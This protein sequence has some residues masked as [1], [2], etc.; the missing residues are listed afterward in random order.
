MEL[1]GVI[2]FLPTHDLTATHHFYADLLHLPLVRDQGDCRIYRVTATAY[3]GFCLRASR[4]VPP[5][6]II[7]TLLVE[8]VEA[9]YAG[10]LAQGAADDHAPR[11]NA[12]YRIIHAFVRD[13]NGYRVELQ[14]F[15][16]PLET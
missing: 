15:L 3:V 6:S 11:F 13:P 10:L 1:N 8:D 16:D 7:L 9:V 5:E 4:P 12:T 14:R 2:T